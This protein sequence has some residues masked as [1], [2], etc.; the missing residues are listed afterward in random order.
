VINQKFMVLIIC[1]SSFTQRR[2]YT[3]ITHID[4][5]T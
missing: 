4:D 2:S 5:E 3:F 1:R